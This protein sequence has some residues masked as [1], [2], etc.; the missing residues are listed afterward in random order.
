MK[1]YLI[2]ILSAG[3]FLSGCAKN[4]TPQWTKGSFLNQDICTHM[5]SPLD[6]GNE[7]VSSHMELT[8]ESNA[9]N[10]IV[11]LVKGWLKTSGMMNPPLENLTA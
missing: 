10:S 4:Q 8:K 9:Q 5:I 3:A 2:L 1:K 11:N 6:T 7:K